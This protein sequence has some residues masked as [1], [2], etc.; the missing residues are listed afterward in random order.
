MQKADFLDLMQADIDAR[1]DAVAERVAQVVVQSQ[2]RGD[3]T[4]TPA[5]IGEAHAA[6]SI[7]LA[8]RL[9]HT[10]VRDE[11]SR[12]CFLHR[13]AFKDALAAAF[14]LVDWPHEACESVDALRQQESGL[15]NEIAM[16]QSEE[17]C[18]ASAANNDDDIERD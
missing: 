17:A 1:A 7:Y 18:L 6:G 12:R 10:A 15:T 5:T 11:F 8:E 2:R 9:L 16:L 4:W 14:E 13:D 3:V